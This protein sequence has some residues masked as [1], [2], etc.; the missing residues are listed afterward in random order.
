MVPKSPTNMR[1]QAFLVF[2]LAICGCMIQAATAADDGV[3]KALY[4]RQT[5]HH[6][7]KGQPI[8]EVNWSSSDTYNFTWGL[9]GV[10]NYE[11]LMFGCV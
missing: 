2:L 9:T 11:N 10:D 5:N 3:S 4:A 8:P 7:F 1:S 6:L